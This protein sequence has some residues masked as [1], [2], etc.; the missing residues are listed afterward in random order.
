MQLLGSAVHQTQAIDRLEFLSEKAK[1][2]SFSL[3]KR[4]DR[5]NWHQDVESFLPISYCFH[6]SLCFFLE[7]LMLSI[8]RKKDT[9]CDPLNP[10]PDMDYST[11]VA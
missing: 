9:I 10:K 3:Y 7:P 1:H 5:N 8:A 11:I 2:L 4:I 6:I